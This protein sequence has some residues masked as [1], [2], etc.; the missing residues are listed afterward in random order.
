MSPIYQ[1]GLP[2]NFGPLVTDKVIVDSDY[3]GGHL[4]ITELAESIKPTLDTSAVKAL[5]PEEY[6]EAESVIIEQYHEP[7]GTTLPLVQRGMPM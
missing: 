2:T 6:R 7:I 1:Q 4:S 5:F 3:Y